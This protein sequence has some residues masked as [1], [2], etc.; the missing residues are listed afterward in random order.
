[1]DDCEMRAGLRWWY[2]LALGAVV[3]AVYL[4]SPIRS[5]LGD[6]TLTIPTAVS[7][8]HDR[9]VVLDELVESPLIDHYAVWLVDGDRPISGF[10]W[11]VSVVAIPVVVANDAVAM[12]GLTTGSRELVRRGDVEGLEHIAA[13]MTMA[14]GVV[15]VAEL[16]FTRMVTIP[17]RT[18]VRWSL[19]AAMIFAFGTSAWSVASRALWPHGPS[20]LA[21][22][23][24]LVLASR[25]SMGRRTSLTAAGIG[26]LLAVA[27][28][29]RPTS[30]I[31][32][33][34]V[35][36]WVLV[37]NRRLLPAFG[38]GAG[39]VV[40]GWALINRLS[41]FGFMHPYHRS[42]RLA[43][44][45][46]LIEALAAN[47][48]SPA[49][50]LLVFS[51]IVAL[52]AFGV[53]LVVRGGSRDGL[54][55][56]ALASTVGLWIAIGLFPHWWAGWSF[57]PRFMSDVLPF[58]VVLCA[59]ALV[60]MAEGSSHGEHRR[61]PAIL[62]VLVAV[63]AVWSITAHVQGAT[64]RTSACWNAIPVSVDDDPARIWSVRDAQLISGF[65]ALANHP[66]EVARSRREC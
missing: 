39:A 36:I 13:A 27:W 3:L 16:L 38:G 21:V 51:P 20:M 42:G 61:A 18:R 12:T 14:L 31:V 44:H 1:M 9:D 8:V 11:S 41:G 54:E 5:P 15:L 22:L 32:I 60:W 58:V 30:A 26:A 28:A 62:T 10:P 47:L 34:V 64:M 49:R 53:V 6:S 48:I 4:V 17:T 66:A 56:A 65:A 23:A 7:M 63:A 57:G 59:P 37:T 29:V 25:L 45:D 33:V 19:V 52:G 40:I 43:L 46:D 50:G 55:W 24:A 35:G 2:W